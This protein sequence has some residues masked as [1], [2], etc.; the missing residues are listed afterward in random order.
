MPAA[1]SSAGS[2]VLGWLTKLAITLALLGLLAFDG[3][4]LLTANFTAADHAN[5]DASAAADNFKI[6]HDVQQAYNAAAALA[7]KDSETIE[8]KT[9][10]VRHSDGHIT[11]TLHR[12][13]TTLWMHHFSFLKKYTDASA[14]GEGSPPP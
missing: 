8:T 12:T 14:V 6:T 1:G 4:A 2:I 10:T 3:I 7:A 13:A 5:T 9:F 11:L